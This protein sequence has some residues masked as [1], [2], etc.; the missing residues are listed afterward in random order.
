MSSAL[1]TTPRVTQLA[2]QLANDIRA[3]ELRAGDRFLTTA[4]ASKHLGVSSALANRALQMLE[5]RRVIVRQ[6]RSGA[7]VADVPA[8]GATASMLHRVHFLVHQKYLRTEGVG[9]DEVLLGIEHELP[10][11]PVQISFLPVGGE[12]AFVSELVDESQSTQ[13]T[14]GFVLVRASFETQR[15]LSERQ[16]PAVVYGTVYPSIDRLAALTADM[17]A[18]G[19]ELANHLLALGHERIVHLTRQIAYGGDQ[20]TIEGITAALGAAGKG[21]DALSLRF[22]PD[23]EEVYNAEATRL[24]GEITKR[25]GFICRTVRMADAVTRAAADRQLKPGKDFDVTVCEYYLKPGTR[26]RYVHGQSV[27]GSEEQGRR[28]AQLLIAQVKQ[29]GT[30]VRQE[31]IPIRV[32]TPVTTGR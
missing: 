25:T 21:F 7:F 18:I 15:L 19:V 9:Q 5:R 13:R 11:V 8:A 22:L 20:L 4:E 26:P 16:I 27:Y 3:R 29:G 32:E 31:V 1:P 24:V 28:L 14:D 30:G 17:R 23:A 2:D 6:Q 12:S 10:G